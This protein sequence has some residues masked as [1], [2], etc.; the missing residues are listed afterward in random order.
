MNEWIQTKKQSSAWEIKYKKEEGF[1]RNE[2]NEISNPRKSKNP[3]SHHL[4]VRSPNAIHTPITNP[5]AIPRQQEATHP[6]TCSNMQRQPP[7]AILALAASQ[8]LN[9][10]LGLDKH[11]L[12]PF[13]CITFSS[14]NR[15]P[16]LSP[17]AGFEIS[18][19]H[20]PCCL[21]DMGKWNIFYPR[22]GEGVLGLNVWDLF[23]VFRHWELI[24]LK[25]ISSENRFFSLPVFRW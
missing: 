9:G 17:N 24:S 15:A 2:S 21:T 1:V 4:Y 11:L 19:F 16:P 23:R 25:V 20:M 18:L 22:R 13:P 14:A 5:Q 8:C 12:R 10:S 7:S 6:F 3:T